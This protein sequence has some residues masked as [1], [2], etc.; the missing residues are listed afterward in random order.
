VKKLNSTGLLMIVLGIAFFLFV[1]NLGA[2]SNIS[3]RE[4]Q[5]FFD[6]DKSDFSVEI[7][8]TSDE[9]IVGEL[10]WV[11]LNVKNRDDLR[12]RM[13]VQCSILNRDDFQEW[14]GR[15]S[16]LLGTVN[17]N[18]VKDEPFTQTNLVILNGY[19]EET[20]RFTFKVPDSVNG[21]N[22]IMCDAYEQ[23]W[24]VGVDSMESDIVIEP[25]SVVYESS[26]DDDVI[27]PGGDIIVDCY[28]DKDCSNTFLKS[29]K[30]VDGLCVDASDI[31]SLPDDTMVNAWV[32]DHT[33]MVLMIIAGLV[34]I[35]FF[36]VFNDKRGGGVY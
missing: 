24:N 6:G 15:E 22:V 4:I 16:H 27:V 10:F 5:P 25:V 31:I 18:C 13:W 17:D 7:L 19:A 28:T 21:D 11:S 8:G 26:I 23:C 34:L 33:F 36:I 35:G 30:C 2:L 20:V 32:K 3:T 14:L 29:Q 9:A 1:F 12:G